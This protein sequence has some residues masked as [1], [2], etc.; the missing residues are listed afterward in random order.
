MTVRVWKYLIKNIWGGWTVASGVTI[1]NAIG[2]K[3][4][5]SIYE[6]KLSNVIDGKGGIDTICS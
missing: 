2:G 5:D 6:N 1:E 4:N 3:Y